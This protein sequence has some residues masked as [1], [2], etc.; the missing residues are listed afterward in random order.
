MQHEI[1][2]KVRFLSIRATVTG[3]RD[4]SVF[5]SRRLKGVLPG[6]HTHEKVQEILLKRWIL[7]LEAQGHPVTFKTTC[8]FVII[9][10]PVIESHIL[11]RAELVAF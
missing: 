5:R 10:I 8:A 4:N 11:E 9:I 2:I 6:Q 3:Y 1:L 7:D